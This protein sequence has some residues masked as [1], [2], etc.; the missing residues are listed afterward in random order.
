M[1]TV[2]YD[3][4]S[5]CNYHCMEVNYNWMYEQMVCTRICFVYSKENIKIGKHSS[6]PIH[7]VS[8]MCFSS[9][10]SDQFQQHYHTAW[11]VKHFSTLKCRRVHF[12][13]LYGMLAQNLHSPLSAYHLWFFFSWQNWF[14]TSFYTLFFSVSH[15]LAWIIGSFINFFVRSSSCVRSCQV[16][17]CDFSQLVDRKS[18]SLSLCAFMLVRVYLCDIS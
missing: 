14:S 7:A 16:K 12:G 8:T 9:V 3:L 6:N 10:N 2:R 15:S 18:L 13:E 1:T 4:P 5:F 11:D 17:L